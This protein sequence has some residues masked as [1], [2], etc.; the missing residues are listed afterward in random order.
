MAKIKRTGSVVTCTVVVLNGRKTASMHLKPVAGVVCLLTLN[1]R[2]GAGGDVRD[3]RSKFSVA[4]KYHPVFG[5]GQ[6]CV[7]YKQDESVRSEGSEL[8]PDAE[9]IGELRQS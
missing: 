6:S 1:E 3:V 7:G 2:R 4:E 8:Q 9:L 5:V